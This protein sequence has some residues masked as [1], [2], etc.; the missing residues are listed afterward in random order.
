MRESGKD[1]PCHL[2]RKE[3]FT[4]DDPSNV[5]TDYLMNEMGAIFSETIL[6]ELRNKNK[7]THDHLS[8]LDGMHSWKMATELEKK[9]GLGITATNNVAESSFGGLT[10]VLTNHSTV[11]LTSAGAIAMTRQNGDF[12]TKPMFA[13]NKG[14]FVFITC[15]LCIYFL[16]HFVKRLKI[17]HKKSESCIS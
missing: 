4:P 15:V 5:D 2:L 6:K 7:A 17:H 10:Q 3:L 9:A 14:N 11:G 8:S 12:A 1:L 13:R 16:T